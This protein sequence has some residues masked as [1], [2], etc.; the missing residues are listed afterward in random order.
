MPLRVEARGL[1]CPLPVVRGREALRTRP[2]GTILEIVGDDPLLRL[3]VE[4]WCAREGHALIDAAPEP[5]G[6][7]RITLRR[8]PDRP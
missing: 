8:G 3:D 2:E 6:A 7:L 5:D 4:A 1:R